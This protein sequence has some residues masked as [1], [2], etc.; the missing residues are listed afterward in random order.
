MKQGLG[1]RADRGRRGVALVYAL[2]GVFVAAGMVGVMFTMAGVTSTRAE[3]RRGTLEADYLAEGGIEAAKREIQHAIANW[4]QPPESGS[5][6]IDG[7]IVTYTV[8]P[9]GGSFVIEDPAGIQEIH[10]GYEIEAFAVV[11]DS[12][13]VANRVIDVAATP[14]FQF[15]VFYAGDLEVNPGPRMTLGGRVHSNGDMYLSCGDKLTLNTNYVRALGDIYRRR[16]N[17]IDSQGDVYI[18]KWVANPFDSSEPSVFEMMLNR[19]QMTD[20]GVKTSSG[21]DSA[22]DGHDENRDGDYDDV[23]DWLP[24]LPGA[25]D[26]WGPPE[27]YDNGSGHT[28][29]TGEHGVREL[30]TPG[31]GAI[32]MYEETDGG[33]YALQDGVYEY[34][35]PGAG[36]HDKGFFHENA[37]LA[38][39]VAENGLGFDVF[40][41]D[42]EPLPID[43]VLASAI[44]LDKIYDAR[45]ADGSGDR[46]TVVKIDL[47]LLLGTEYWP[48]NGL[49]YAAHYGMGEGADAKGVQLVNGSELQSGLTVATEGSIFIQGDYNTFEKKGAA[50]IADAVSLLSNAWDGTKYEGDLP[51]AEDTQFNCALITGNYATEAGQ[52]NGG[53]ENLPRFHEKWADKKC[54]IAGSFVNLWDSQYATGLWKYG[55]DHYT[56]PLRVWAYERMFN[57]V[58]KLPP[59]TPMVVSANDVVSW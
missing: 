16:K 48:E 51:L 52:Y 50:V 3:V 21:Y 54:L 9:T 33:S 28:V 45:Q 24:F 32:K 18:R 31:I 22:F 46:T 58:A 57:D 10:T 44:K 7:R 42:G 56:A 1:N 6:D 25:L 23:L 2:F 12:Q 53:L 59:F 19:G 4:R 13:A 20:A 43:D 49:V 17:N 38:I 14:I 55:D 27:D 41:P 11:D 35:G 47:G 15:A 39:V 5:V 40:G 30:T 29:L 26:L 34:V 37:D 36:T 8:E